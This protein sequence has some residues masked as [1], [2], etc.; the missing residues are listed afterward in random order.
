MK[1]NPLSLPVEK[2]LWAV[3]EMKVSRTELHEAFGSPHYIETD[4]SRTFGGEEDCWAFKL[5]SGLRV[6]IVFRVPYGEAVIYSD[7]VDMPA[8]VSFLEVTIIDPKIIV[9]NTPSPVQ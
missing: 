9:Y 8:M 5:E 3:G 7:P 2:P 4:G 1:H 6:L